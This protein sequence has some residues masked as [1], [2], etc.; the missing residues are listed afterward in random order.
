MKFQIATGLHA[1]LSDKD[2]KAKHLS[3]DNYFSILCLKKK[4]RE[5]IDL[6]I[7]GEN[8]LA[9]EFNVKVDGNQYTAEDPAFFEKLQGIRKDFE[10]TPLNFIP[11]DEF[12]KWADEL[13]I[14]SGDLLAEYLLKTE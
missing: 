12:K 6:T 3:S 14:N 7:E 1:V 11:K 2:L 9:E 13:D 10:F 4:L 8:K 5:H